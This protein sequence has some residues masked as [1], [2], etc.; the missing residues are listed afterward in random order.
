MLS[1]S[2]RLRLQEILKRIANN[3]E[4]SLAERVYLHKFADRD[5]TVSVWLNKAKRIQQQSNGSDSIDNLL[6]ELG[7]GS[8]D[9]QSIYNPNDDDLGDWFKGAPSW[10]GRS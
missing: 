10:L 6:D 1:T 7:L 5:Q 2:T 4:V 3:E 8:C 9:P